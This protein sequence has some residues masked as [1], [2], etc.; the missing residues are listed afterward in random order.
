ML[1]QLRI[2]YDRRYE[3]RGRNLRLLPFGTSVVSGRLLQELPGPE[4][5]GDSTGVAG[6]A[7]G[8]FSPPPF[9]FV[10][11]DWTAFIG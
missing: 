10:L 8:Q 1:G 11:K 5:V 7:L 3:V 6:I 9:A 4:L 2:P